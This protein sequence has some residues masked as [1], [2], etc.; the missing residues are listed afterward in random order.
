MLGYQEAN[1]AQAML[2][3]QQNFEH[4]NTQELQLIQQETNKEHQQI[5]LQDYYDRVLKG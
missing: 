1:L 3:D 5:L 2:R 4:I